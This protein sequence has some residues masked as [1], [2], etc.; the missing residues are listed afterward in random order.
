MT[1]PPPTRPSLLVRIRDNGDREAW[2]QFVDLYAPLVY[3]FA[4]RRGLQDADAADL[5]QEV[6]QAVAGASIRNNAAPTEINRASNEHSFGIMVGE[7][8]QANAARIPSTPAR[9][10]TRAW[11]REAR[12]GVNS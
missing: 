3:K 4:R 12:V 6:L 5:T 11:L 1:T 2:R 7:F 8:I 9:P 10:E